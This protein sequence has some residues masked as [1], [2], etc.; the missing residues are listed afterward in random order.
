MKV[1]IT[2]PQFPDVEKC[3]I[4]KRSEIISTPKTTFKLKYNTKKLNNRLR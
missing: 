4:A 1:E 2:C 3:T